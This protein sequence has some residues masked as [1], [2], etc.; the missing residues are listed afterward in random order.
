[1]IMPAKRT[2]T[3]ASAVTLILLALSAC[4]SK[5]PDHCKQHTGDGICIDNGVV[6]NAS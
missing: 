5:A 6:G 4:A 2:L 3:Q 1:M